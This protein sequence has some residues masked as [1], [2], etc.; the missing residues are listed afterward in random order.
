MSL[1]AKALIYAITYIDALPEWQRER[2]DQSDMKAILDVMVK[3]DNHLAL[4][5]RPDLNRPAGEQQ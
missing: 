1:I 2:S 5:M 4:L 3:D